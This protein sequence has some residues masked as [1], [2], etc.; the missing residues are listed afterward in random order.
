MPPSKRISH[1]CGALCGLCKSSPP[2]IPGGS[3]L[4][5]FTARARALPAAR[6]PAR[7]SLLPSTYLPV[8][9]CGGFPTRHASSAPSLSFGRQAALQQVEE[10][11]HIVLAWGGKAS[12]DGQVRLRECPFCPKPH[13]NQPTN[14]NSL[15]IAPSYASYHCHRCAASGNWG[16]LERAMQALGYAAEAAGGKED[17]VSAAAL[18]AAA[19]D[20]AG[21]VLF[22]PS[23]LQQ[24]QQPRPVDQDEAK[25]Y[26]SLLMSQVWEG[27]SH[28]G[29]NFLKSRGLQRPVC[30]LYKVG[31]GMF[32]FQD[33]KGG[34]QNYGCVTF[35][36]L[37]R[38]GEFGPDALGVP[39]RGP[40]RQPPGYKILR[41]K[42]R[43]VEN[44][45]VRRAA[46]VCVCGADVGRRGLGGR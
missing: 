9:S 35:P 13:N 29:V 7:P 20:R 22:P 24:Q 28:P 30:E 26:V 17:A 25:A 41:T 19:V 32:S 8:A 46:F 44:K 37:G 2:T 6:T 31:Y 11:R 15:V 38:A 45:A 3:R 42:I 18:A 12:P 1:S 14:L 10:R 23:P 40:D 21:H 27:S 33:A 16:Q 5:S 39:E 34:W 43:G 4:V 36:W